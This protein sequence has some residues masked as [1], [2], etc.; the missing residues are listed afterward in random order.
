MSIFTRHRGTIELRETSRTAVFLVTLVTLGALFLVIFATTGVI[1]VAIPVMAKVLSV[2][3][4]AAGA[5]GALAIP[6][7]YFRY[8]V[9]VKYLLEISTAGSPPKAI[10]WGPARELIARSD[11]GSLAVSHAHYWRS[12]R[13]GGFRGALVLHT[14]GQPLGALACF[15]SATIHEGSPK[16]DT[17]RLGD[18]Y[19]LEFE[20]LAM[21][22]RTR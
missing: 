2:A 20:Q 21:L 17:P 19:P 22:V 18:L 12:G 10:L 15:G 8:G 7:V 4:L 13:Y 1:L 9:P 6:F 16:I 11:D 3:C 14:H 5:L